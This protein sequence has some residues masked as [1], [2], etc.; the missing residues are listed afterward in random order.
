MTGFLILGSK[1]TADGDCSHEIR[2]HLLLGR[3]AMTNL[4]SVLKNRHYPASRG[5][6]CQGCG[7]PSVH[8][9]LWEL[10]HKEG[11]ALKNWCLRTMVLEK[12]PESPLNS[13]EIKPVNLMGNQPWILIG[14]TDAKVETSVFWSSDANSWLIG[15]VPDAEKDW[16]QKEQRVSEGEMAGWHHQCS[17]GKL[18]EME[19]NGEA[20]DAAIHGVTKSQ[21]WLDKGQSHLK[22]SQFTFV[23]PTLRF[24][25]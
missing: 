5:M 10:D 17:L 18:W 15:K 4:G 1:I 2:R 9:Q 21:T 19:K 14:R 6:Y 16:G 12:T 20:W 24:K 7:L 25:N 22:Y 11:R 13:N 23:V 3:K 8:I